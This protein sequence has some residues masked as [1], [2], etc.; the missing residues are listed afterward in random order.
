MAQIIEFPER[1]KSETSAPSVDF[2]DTASQRAIVL[3]EISEDFMSVIQRLLNTG[4]SAS[5]IAVMLR[6]QVAILEGVAAAMG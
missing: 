3:H 2:S 4:F 5:D 6:Q 1:R